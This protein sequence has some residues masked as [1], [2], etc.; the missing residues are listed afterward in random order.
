MTHE[1]GPMRRS[2][3]VDEHLKI[4]FDPTGGAWAEAPAG[5]KP[6]TFTSRALKKA[7]ATSSAEISELCKRW[8]EK[9]DVQNGRAS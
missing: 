4:G 3:Q 5:E 1:D 9:W 8:A 6:D 2:V 7:G